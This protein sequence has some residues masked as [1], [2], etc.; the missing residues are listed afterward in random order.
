VTEKRGPGSLKPPRWSAERRA[1]RVMGR[2][3][4]RKRLAC[5]VTCTPTGVSQTPERLSALRPPPQRG[6]SEAKRQSPDA[7]MRVRER[8]GLFDIVNIAIGRAAISVRSSPRKRG[9]MITGRCSWV[10]ALATFGRDDSEVGW[11]KSLTDE[12]SSAPLPILLLASRGPR[13][14]GPMI[15]FRDLFAQAMRRDRRREDRRS[16]RARYPQADARR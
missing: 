11:A 6:V 13:C 8:A 5:R 2:K 4:P 3:A 15:T 12:S 7:A 16:W 1:S 14:G 9:P 10:P